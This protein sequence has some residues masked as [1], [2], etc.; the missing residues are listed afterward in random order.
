MQYIEPRKVRICHSGNQ[1]VGRLTLHKNERELDSNIGRKKEP[2]TFYMKVTYDS[3]STDFKFILTNFPME[4]S[5]VWLGF[6]R[7]RD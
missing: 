5:C 1:I 6:Y 3:S 4:T 7:N 2:R